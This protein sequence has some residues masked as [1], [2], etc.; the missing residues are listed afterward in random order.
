MSRRPTVGTLS[1]P[2]WPAAR[3]SV[4]AG[5]LASS[6]PA[7]NEIADSCPLT[8][9]CDGS[10]IFVEMSTACRQIVPGYYR[11]FYFYAYRN[12]ASVNPAWEAR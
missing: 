5:R 1:S 4:H 7:I 8:I 11:P 12:T 10:S 3:S 6:S 2:N 9:R